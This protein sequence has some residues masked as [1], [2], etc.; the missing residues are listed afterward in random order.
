MNSFTIN[1]YSTALYAT[2]YLIEE[3]GLLFDAGDG[4][5][6]GLTQKSGKIKQVF[7]SHADRDHITGLLQLNAL[8]ARPG[9]PHIYYPADSGSFPALR[10]FS[11]RFDPQVAH[12]VWQGIRP[13]AP[14]AISKEYFI[15][16]LS[17]SHVPAAPGQ[18]KSLSYI[19]YYVKHKLREEFHGMTGPEIARLRKERG[20]EAVM[21]EVEEPVLAYS[22]DT[23]VEDPKRF[24]G[25]PILI[26]EA[27]FLEADDPADETGRS[28]RHSTLPAVMK[29]AAGLDL[30]YLILGHFSSR[31]T[32]DE[33]VAAVREQCAL[34][35]IRYPVFT[36]LPGAHYADILGGEACWKP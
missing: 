13:G 29:M 19:L 17:N 5:A 30:Q 11:I 4:A 20:D 36:V 33:I 26:H 9:I 24:D 15:R 7:I 1:G 32:G 14:V 22:G 31:Y 12:T 35:R 3:L 25:V 18:V 6:A 28:D 10:D 8:N 27:T 34:H 2:W 21:E 23:P 16:P